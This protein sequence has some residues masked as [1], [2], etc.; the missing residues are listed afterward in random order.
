MHTGRVNK[1]LCLLQEL[2]GLSSQ[3]SYCMHSEEGERPLLQALS[4]LPTFRHLDFSVGFQGS[5]PPDLPL[6][7]RLTCLEAWWCQLGDAPT[8]VLAQCSRLR[9]LW[10]DSPY[11][12]YP[13]A[14]GEQVAPALRALAALPDFEQLELP[15]HRVGPPGEEKA[16]AA[17]A[18]LL[19]A[20]PGLAHINERYDPGDEDEGSQEH[21]E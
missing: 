3:L 18:E 12:S 13:F 10:L 16:Q 21:S 2:G 20:R 4:T 1:D 19:A 5:L 17:L 11:R 8:A 9:R 7:T 15:M 14:S 6:L